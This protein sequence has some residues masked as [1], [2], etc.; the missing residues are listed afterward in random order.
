M[1]NRTACT[2]Y[3]PRSALPGVTFGVPR[4]QVDKIRE[5]TVDPVEFPH[6]RSKKL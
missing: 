5:A 4:E 1:L 2:V 6:G 3:V